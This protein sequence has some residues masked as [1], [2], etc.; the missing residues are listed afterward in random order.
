MMK[1]FL[2]CVM[3]MAISLTVTG[4][5]KLTPQA[6]L[7]I[8][9]L[10]DNGVADTHSKKRNEKPTQD[11]N[12]LTTMFVVNMSENSNASS[13]ISQM[14]EAGG[15]VQSRLG[16]QVVIKL[17]VDSVYALE[18]IDGVKC[19]DIGHKGRIKTDVTRIET[20]V[21]RLNG[22]GDDVMSPSYTGKGV[23]ICLLDIGFDFQHPAFKDANGNSRIKCV[24]MMTDDNG[25]KFTVND[26]D[27]GEY[28]FPG[29]VYDT[30][31]LIATLTTDTNKEMHGSHTAAIAA[32]SLSPQGFG[33]MAPEADIVLVPI[34]P[35]YA[36]YFEDAQM[37][38]I[39]EIALSFASAYARK[40]GQPM[41]MSG[42]INSHN[43]SHDGTS[44]VNLAI[45]E[46]SK[47][48]IP[49]MSSGN[50]GDTP[51]HL[52]HIFTSDEPSIKTVL[53]ATMG[54]E[55]MGID[56]EENNEIETNGIVVTGDELG[57]QIE[58]CSFD[59]LEETTTTLW[60]SEICKAKRGEKPAKL[61]V[62]NKT[63]PNLAKYFTG[64]VSYEISE[65]S[66]GQLCF[67]GEINGAIPDGELFIIT[68]NGA[69]GTEL[70]AWNDP[71]GFSGKT[72]SPEF[73][74]GDNN[75]S[76]GDWTCTDRVISVGAYCANT[77]KRNMDGSVGD[78]N[79]DDDD[80]DF[81]NDDDDFVYNFSKY[82]A[83]D[84][85]D[86][87]ENGDGD[88]DGDD[89][90]VLYDIAPFS[91]FGTSVNNV[92][93]PI[94]CAPGTYVVSAFNHYALDSDDVDLVSESMSW[95]GFPYESEDGTSMSCP[96]V[97]GIVALWLQAKP[98]MTFENVVDV[99][100]KTART[101]EFTE[102]N[103]ERWGYGKID[104]VK[105]LEYVL[106]STGIEYVNHTETTFS[107][108][109]PK[110]WYTI[111]GRKL[112]GKPATKGMYIHNGKKVALQ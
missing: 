28:T 93:Q 76:A 14:K 25:N 63:D 52:H 41:V 103:P 81:N 19:I 44:S 29:S 89:S 42:S 71:S 84:D 5:R 104:A 105:G 100:S 2:F 10:K 98:D 13:T 9:S 92:S 50:E 90:Y 3:M 67:Y 47:T 12:L 61:S 83:N 27:A 69:D 51:V 112:N 77:Q 73:K 20:G 97:S 30:P 59:F 88:N 79:N 99:L 16:R 109:L 65:N 80:D 32:G 68:F 53:G 22:P 101:D 49:V 6:E 78:G 91:S 7:R 102:K 4:Q 37:E 87:D 57:I 36:S 106:H 18:R 94:I 38:S 111:D 95:N 35:N 66:N 85:D 39:I 26:P 62:S 34:S 40:S 21:S 60:S 8:A 58:L 48:V 74:D 86:D 108:N 15:I 82:R 54:D 96:V 11:D 23:T 75:L 110:G 45:E 107:Y 72:Y 70:H 55:E 24:Y 43:G 56:P 17:P 64:E 31:E 1:R 33:G 46:L